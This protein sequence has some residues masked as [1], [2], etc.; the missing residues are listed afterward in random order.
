MANELS[1]IVNLDFSKGG[2]EVSK[3]YSKK[4]TI[5]GDA[6]TNG[7]QAIGVAEEEIAQGI[8][9]GTPGYMLI[10]NLDT[11]NYVEVGSTTGVYDIKLKALEFAL[12]RHNSGTVYAKA[13]TDTCNVEYCLI[14]D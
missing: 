14:E 3:Q 5:T 13:D 4:V 9:L 11:T 10:K 1:L 2:A 7:I 8:D 6:F 12:Y